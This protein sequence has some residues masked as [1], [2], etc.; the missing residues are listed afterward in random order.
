M[1]SGELGRAK[2]ALPVKTET[3]D[4]DSPQKAIPLKEALEGIWLLIQKFLKF[5]LI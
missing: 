3:G 1:G 5:G 2:R 4:K